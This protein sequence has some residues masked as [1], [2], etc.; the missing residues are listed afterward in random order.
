[1]GYIEHSLARS[2]T[3]LYRARFPAFY[4]IAAWGVLLASVLGAL[5]VD[6]SG[7]GP[8]WIAMV[9]LGV[10]AFLGILVPIWT[11]EIG[12]TNQ[13]FVF[14]RGLLW[15]STQELQ[16]RAV[17]E[18]NLEQGLLGRLLNFGRLELRGTGRRRRSLARAGRPHGVETCTA[19]WHGSSR[20]GRQR[21]TAATRPC[22]VIP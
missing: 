17:E 13:R 1:M 9:L 7:Y 8:L 2:E 4:F 19:R 20:C 22:R 6:A 15:R 14:K 11:T 3:L 5:L 10:V 16:L 21:G 12:V 18:V